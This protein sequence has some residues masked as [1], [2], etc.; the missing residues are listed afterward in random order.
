MNIN[1]LKNF[2][3]ES[4]LSLVI[5]FFLLF[6]SFLY[7]KTQME[8]NIN[9]FLINDKQL[10]LTQYHTIYDN[11]NKL[12]QNSFYGII[13]KP[14]VYNLVKYA[15]KKD[16][17]TKAVYRKKLYDNLISDYN[18]LLDY[19]FYQVHFH[20]PDN[21]SFL[22][23][24]KPDAFG[25]DLSDYRFS[26]S[27]VNKSLKP[28][29]GYEIG[30]IVDGFRFVYPLFDEKLF[31]IGSLELSVSSDFFEKNFEMN[32]NVDSHFLI[33]KSIAE[34]KIYPEYL[35]EF[36]I[37]NENKDYIYKEDNKEFIHYSSKNFY[38]EDEKE[39]ISSK[40]QNSQMF[41]LYKKIDGKY[42]AISFLPI[43][44]VENEIN[45]AYMVLY[46]NSDYI[47]Q[48]MHNYYKMLFILFL[49][50]LIYFFY[51]NYRY[52]KI[53]A[54][55]NKDYILSQQTKM[56]ALG[57]MIQNIS[58]QWRQ[59]LSVISV[60]ASGLK[61]KKECN[62]LEDKELIENLN[63][64][65]KNTNYLS[66]TIEDFRNYFEGNLEKKRFNLKDIVNQCILMFKE[67]ISSKNVILIENLNDIELFTYE[68]ELK[69]VIINLLKNAKD[70]TNEGLIIVSIYEKKEHIIIEIQDSA[71]GIPKSIIKKIFD[72]Y[73]TTKHNSNGVGL[74]LFSAYEIID[75]K[76]KGNI[77]VENKEFTYYFNSYKGACFSIILDR[78]NL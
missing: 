56:A 38:T 73:F 69:Q 55:K 28:V 33:K 57:E 49:F 76:L 45:S 53:Q 35:K 66:N 22:R 12:S 17:A 23:M 4:L 51:I 77:S 50:I 70:F 43:K 6:S 19:K 47:E 24:H 13:N 31:H 21:T 30:K 32:F 1:N 65:L 3:K 63:A 62:I 36:E 10:Y 11:F 78:K 68:S 15:Y 39:L 40:M 41:S 52:R 46:K 67:E 18:R 60:L 72:P 74:G 2:I 29:H 16:D 34:Y 27:E 8:N 75:K 48:V 9:N 20:F 26:V 14:E 64:I 59:P 44:N 42:L 7:F 54:E 37:S 61:L 71:G 58:H 5:F 25:D